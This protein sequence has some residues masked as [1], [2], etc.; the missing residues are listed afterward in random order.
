MNRS[1]RNQWQVQFKIPLFN[2]LFQQT[3]DEEE[4]AAPIAA[5]TPSQPEPAPPAAVEKEKEAEIYEFSQKDKVK[6]F[7]PYF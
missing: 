7:A 1:W 2:S 3:Q 5:V 4:A 6:T